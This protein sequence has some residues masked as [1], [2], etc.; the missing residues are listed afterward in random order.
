MLIIQVKY[1]LIKEGNHQN[2]GLDRSAEATGSG[3][4]IC[5]FDS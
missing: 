4:L 2:S 3:V 5:L 1:F